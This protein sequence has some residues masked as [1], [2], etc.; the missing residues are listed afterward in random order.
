[1]RSLHKLQVRESLFVCR[2]PLQIGLITSI[3]IGLQSG[4]ILTSKQV[5]FCR[6]SSS[7]YNT[8]AYYLAI[9]IIATLESVRLLTDDIREN[10]KKYVSIE[11]F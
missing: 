7:G 4:R 3:L 5:E 1:M 2:Y 11:I 6:E 10:P 9:N 8:N